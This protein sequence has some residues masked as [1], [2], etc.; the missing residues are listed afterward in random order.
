MGGF[1]VSAGVLTEPP[2]EVTRKEHGGRLFSGCG[3]C[4]V[5][6]R[7]RGTGAPL[8]GGLRC[9][10]DAQFMSEPAPLPELTPSTGPMPVPGDPL[11]GGELLSDALRSE[12]R[13]AAG[14][15]GEPDQRLPEP[16]PLAREDFL[17]TTPASVRE[18][19]AEPDTA[20]HFPPEKK[21]AP[22]PVPATTSVPAP[23]LPAEQPRIISEPVPLLQSHS[24]LHIPEEPTTVAPPT[25]PLAPATAAEL[26]AAAESIPP[27]VQEPSAAT[28]PA[29]AP[30]PWSVKAIAA[31]A[32]GEPMLDVPAF[33]VLSRM[34]Q[35]MVPPPEEDP[36]PDAE[37]ASVFSDSSASSALESS[38][39]PASPVEMDSPAAGP[40]DVEPPAAPENSSPVPETT[41][42]SLTTL[43]VTADLSAGEVSPL[44]ATAGMAGLADQASPLAAADSAAAAPAGPNDSPGLVL[45]GGVLV[46]CGLGLAVRIPVLLMGNDPGYAGTGALDAALRQSAA[47][48]HGAGA[49]V[50]L[51]LGLGAATARRW[52]PPLIHG[53]G[54]AVLLGTLLIL[55]QYSGLLFHGANDGGPDVSGGLGRLALV[56][57]CGIIFPLLAVAYCD[58]Q[59]V[60]ETCAAADPKPRWT[61]PL[62][63]PVLMLFCTALTMGAVC[64]AAAAGPLPFPLGDRAGPAPLWW[65]AAAVWLISA[66]LCMR[67]AR[68]AW[69]LAFTGFLGLA[70]MAVLAFRTIPLQAVLSGAG[71][72]PAAS[73]AL[74]PQDFAAWVTLLLPL[75]VILF[76]TRRAFGKS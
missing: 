1:M 50:L 6:P 60:L 14:T 74:Q 76:M 15:F 37:H 21:T 42:V 23:A 2:A 46:V 72:D 55:A 45:L 31:S 5:L 68:A 3:R 27:E 11:A 26:P 48:L 28:V 16:E 43:P 69:L 39:S 9:G 54:W 52:A 13:A 33:P 20:A 10:M 57:V 70:A 18:A 22:V 40:E 66:V 4:T 35:L 53:A 47:V 71:S 51:A 25:A 58:R 29:A 67:R 36:A 19:I 41:P 75:L 32:R 63:V 17:L 59:R 49:A 62:P 73:A 12:M 7:R 56:T 61:D 34:A 64:A 30:A 44:F 65:A 38:A 8:A 24:F